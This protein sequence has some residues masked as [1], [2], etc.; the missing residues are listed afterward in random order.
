MCVAGSGGGVWCVYAHVCACSCTLVDNLGCC[1]S[2]PFTFYSF[3]SAPSWPGAHYSGLP[4]WPVRPWGP[5]Y[6]NLLVLGLVLP[7]HTRQSAP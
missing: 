7:V 4:G 6:V 3:S 2:G 1:F 5:T